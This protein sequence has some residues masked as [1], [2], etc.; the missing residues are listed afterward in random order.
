MRKA[1]IA[2]LLLAASPAFAVPPA[3]N[4]QGKLLDANGAPRNGSFSMTF[5]IWDAASGGSQLWTETQGAVAV[6]NGVFAVQL[7]GSTPVPASLFAA[8]ERYLQVQI[9][10]E[11]ASARQRLVT[12]P[13][14]FRAAAADDLE[15]G[16]GD[17]VQNRTTLQAGAT[18]HVSSGTVA[19][20]LAVTG[21]L[22][23]GS[24]SQ[25]ITTAAGLLDASK[26]AGAIPPASLSGT[27]A[28][29]T[30]GALL[31]GSTNYVQNR[32]TLQSGAQ[33]HVA[34]AAVAGPFT[35]TGTVTLGGAA[36]VNDVSVQSD[37]LVSGD[38]RV[39]GNDLRDSAGAA[40]VT[41]GADIAI[42]GRLVPASGAT[43][44]VGT[45]LRITGAANGDNFVAYPMTAG[46][47]IADRQIVVISGANTVTNTTSANNAA[48]IGFAVNDATAG[49]T[50]WVATSGIVTGVTSGA[51]VAVGARVCA[52]NIV[53]R[54]QSCTTDG[55]V[56]GKSLTG[57]TGSGQTLTVVLTG[58][59]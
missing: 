19:G 10:G 27:Y 36:G 45:P 23:A 20:P 38:L 28:S 21:V 50:V 16:D 11:T 39:N 41:L 3:I 12:S 40:R 6:S 14:A 37:L 1:L 29:L 47:T 35:A 54:V 7:G 32:S 42:E 46:G 15:A 33:F 13:F 56:I 18:F 30:A 51:A 31:P 55:A 59:N 2:L 53:G 24:G 57:T 34:Q 48:A 52:D 17:Y 49:E 25:T 22:V 58:G 5:A 26:L 44:S 9:G 8:G 4:F 43:L